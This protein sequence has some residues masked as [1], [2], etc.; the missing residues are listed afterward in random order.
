MQAEEAVTKATPPIDL[1]E[2]AAVVRAAIREELARLP[3]APAPEV[4]S[5]ALEEETP[6]ASLEERL[7]VF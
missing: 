3:A 2:L 1:D 5:E 4:N 6:D 7:I